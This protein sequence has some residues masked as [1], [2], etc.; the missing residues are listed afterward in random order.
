MRFCEVI[1]IA[2]SSVRAIASQQLGEEESLATQSFL[3]A[4]GEG[5]K[6]SASIK[7]EQLLGRLHR[8]SS[9][10]AHAIC[11]TVNDLWASPT[12]LT[13]CQL[14]GDDSLLYPA[15]V[16]INQKPLI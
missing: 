11:S 16:V 8:L 14:R 2:V 13:K 5:S 3:I 15:Q 9:Q 4:M 12:H 6:C 1:V 10:L 7:R